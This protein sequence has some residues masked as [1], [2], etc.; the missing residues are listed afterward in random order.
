[1]RG[2]AGRRG[3]SLIVL[4]RGSPAPSLPAPC[5]SWRT[6]ALAP[7]PTLCIAPEKGLR[8]AHPSACLRPAS[9]RLPPLQFVMRVT[10]LRG[11][12]PAEWVAD[13]ASAMEGFG[14]AAMQQRPQLADI[15]RELRGA[16]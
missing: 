1:M 14:V 10:A 2:L 13:F 15:Y 5:S 4:L 9:P 11:S 12:V 7:A 3:F 6:H 8:A 16:K